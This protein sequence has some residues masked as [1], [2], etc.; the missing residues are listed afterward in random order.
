MGELQEAQERLRRARNAHDASTFGGRG[1][2]EE[3]QREV[4]R[5]REFDTSKIPEISILAG[6]GR[7]PEIGE[8]VH[9]AKGFKFN[10]FVRA[11]FETSEGKTRVV[12]EHAFEIGM[13]HIYAPEQLSPGHDI[14]FVGPIG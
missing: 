14:A 2:I 5:L 11:V 12:V 13:L 1:R 7:M 8:A 10:G 6:L 9:K 4:D 3:A